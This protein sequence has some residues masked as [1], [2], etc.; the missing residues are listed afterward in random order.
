MRKQ[1]F[2]SSLHL[3]LALFLIVNISFSFL[4]T[5]KAQALSGS[6]WRAGRIIDDFV[7]FNPSTMNVG[8]IQ[9]F[10]NSKV[11][12]CDTN[13]SAIYSG[14][15]TR[16][17]YSATKGYTPPFTCLKD[18]QQTTVAKPAE[19][20]LCN[21]YP[22]VNQSS[23]EIIYGVAQS[24][25]VNPKVLLVLLQKEQSLVTDDWPWSIQYRSATGYGCPD[26]APCDA[27]YYGFF[28]QVYAAARQY[29]YYAK[30][31]TIFGYRANRNNTI[32]YNPNAG[33]GSSQVYIQNQ[34]TAGLYIYTP[35]QPNQAA[36]N[37]LLGTGDGCSAYGNRNFWRL[38]N[39]WFGTTLADC[40]LVDMA[41][42]VQRLFNPQTNDYLYT[43]NNIESCLAQTMYG[44]VAD[45]FV[46][47]VTPPESGGVA[48]Y[49]LS[50]PSGR[51]FYTTSLSEKNSLVVNAGFYYEGVGFTA[52]NTP[53]TG[54]T[55]V[56]RMAPR[57]N[58]SHFYTASAAEKN[59]LAS[60][61]YVN[62]GITFYTQAGS[63]ANMP[64]YRLLAPSGGHFY[65]T[66]SA[67]K[68]NAISS[69]GYKDE[70]TSFV[71]RSSYTAETIPVYRL[72]SWPYHKFTP[73]LA[74][75]EKM[76]VRGY[77]NES[78][79]FYQ[80][81]SGSKP[82]YRLYR[83]QDGDHLLTTSAYERDLAISRNGYVYE[84]V[85]FYSY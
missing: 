33:C 35:Y 58:S 59:D 52:K 45:D 76:L 53:A 41:G 25:G 61:G 28:N 4:L 29:K 56:Y 42:R 67:E 32:Q 21:G 9:N 80:P 70:G 60:K 43:T 27:Q 47:N 55:P 10:L 5:P 64:V 46:F 23:A 1:I 48:V 17:A 18:Y 68:A 6:D 7:F 16:K 71:G 39:E 78:I 82:V 38:Y 81:S 3:I 14:S 75:R 49:R 40:D 83:H 19:A 79:S 26:T 15:T 66:S 77:K 63:E 37:N 12:T 84:G 2:H 31:P 72:M 85:T 62:E 8:T 69:L 24:C 51:H 73:S 13:G 54:Y 20:G 65:T 22:V 50:T 30:N 11:P 57:G 36:L 74:E 34:A 44:Y